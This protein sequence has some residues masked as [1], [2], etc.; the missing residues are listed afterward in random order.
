[1]GLG[2]WGLLLGRCWLGCECG[3]EGRKTGVL[4]IFGWVHGVRLDCCI[5]LLEN[6][7][8]LKLNE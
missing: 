4:G 7:C 3:G 6:G 8:A 2:C 1:M 5:A